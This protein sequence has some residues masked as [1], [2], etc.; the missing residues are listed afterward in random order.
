MNSI[1]NLTKRTFVTSNS[2]QTNEYS[3]ETLDTGSSIHAFL[4]ST[5]FNRLV[6]QYSSR[7]NKRELPGIGM[8]WVWRRNSVGGGWRVGGCTLPHNFLL[9]A[10]PRNF[11]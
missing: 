5:T 11:H 8:L 10:L 3:L 4:T 2:H 1:L 9:V 7:R 6:G